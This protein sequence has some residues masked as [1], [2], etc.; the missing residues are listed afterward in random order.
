[1][2]GECESHAYI[3]AHV[4]HKVTIS[5]VGK[6]KSISAH[7]YTQAVHTSSLIVVLLS[8]CLFEC[9]HCLAWPLLEAFFAASQFYVWYVHCCDLA[10]CVE[11]VDTQIYE[12]VDDVLEAIH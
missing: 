6:V 8:E 9:V 5:P 12:L 10:D 11:K 1:M 4:M 7:W 3:V 2:H